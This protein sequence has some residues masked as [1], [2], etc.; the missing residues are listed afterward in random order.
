MW[1][2]RMDNATLAGVVATM[3]S[4]LALIVS[5]VQLLYQYYTNVSLNALGARNCNEIV[6]GPWAKFTRR[7]WRWSELRSETIFESP[8][9]FMNS[10]SNHDREPLPLQDIWY[11]DGSQK[12]YE[13]TRTPLPEDLSPAYET[14]PTL[15]H[16]G[17]NIEATW[18][19][20]LRTLQSTEQEST[21]WNETRRS[22]GNY[23]KPLPLETRP[24][25]VGVQVQ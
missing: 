17:V 18:V 13:E 9:L 12:S 16:Q 23:E 3:I 6:K 21:R 15:I 1:E 20:L 14:A 19:L 8:F 7:R 2:T 25:A 24:L 4:F 10:A 11:I 5:S 22:F